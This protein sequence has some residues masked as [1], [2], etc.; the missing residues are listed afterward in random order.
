MKSQSI[1]L[2]QEIKEI[3]EARKNGQKVR[4]VLN[5]YIS[6][7][8]TLSMQVLFDSIYDSGTFLYFMKDNVCSFNLDKSLFKLSFSHFNQFDD[9]SS[10]HYVLTLL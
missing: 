8:T 4:Y 6:N 1:E 3:I 2:K 10:I 5:I 9:L 7:R